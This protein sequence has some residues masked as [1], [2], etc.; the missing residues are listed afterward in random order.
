M[1]GIVVSFVNKTWTLNC[2]GTE[3]TLLGVDEPKVLGRVIVFQK[4]GRATL[5]VN[6][7]VGIRLGLADEVNDTLGMGFA[8]VF[9]LEDGRVVL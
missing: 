1:N 9:A 6:D 3:L 5:E 4:L 2:K 7:T 8:R